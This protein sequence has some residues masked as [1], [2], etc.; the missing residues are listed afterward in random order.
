MQTKHRAVGFLFAGAFLILTGF[1]AASCKHQDTV[2]AYTVRFEQPQHGKLTA[3][4]KDGSEIKSG[5]KVLNGATVIFTADPEKGYTVEKWTGELAAEAA[6]ERNISL[7]VTKDITAGVIFKHETAPPSNNPGGNQTP[8]GGQTPGNEQQYTVKFTQP[9]HGRLTAKYKEN[10]AY[11]T[12]GQTV[13]KGTTVIFTARQDPHF[14]IKEWTGLPVGMDATASEQT[15]TVESDLTVTVVFEA[16]PIPAGEIRIIFDEKKI[17]CRDTAKAN[18][19]FT[20]GSVT[21]NTKLEFT[22]FSTTEFESWCINNQPKSHE[23]TFVYEV[24]KADAQDSI[25]NV[26]YTEKEKPVIEFEKDKITVTVFEFGG[27]TIQSGDKVS[28][29]TALL[30]NVKLQPDKTVEKWMINGT[31]KA[32]KFEPRGDNQYQYTV[33]DEDAVNGKISVTFTEKT[34][35]KGKISFDAGKIAVYQWKDNKWTEISPETSIAQENKLAFRSKLPFGTI[36]KEWKI[37]IQP[38][39]HTDSQYVSN[40]IV[41]ST[42]FSSGQMNITITDRPA[43]K[44]SIKFGEKV[45]C[46]KWTPITNEETELKDGDAIQETDYLKVKSD[47]PGS[48]TWTIN[49]KKYD[50][51]SPF[52]TDEFAVKSEY[53]NSNVLKI[54]FH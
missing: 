24:K 41:K 42:D 8:D 5:D 11:I 51:S 21:E 33:A 6:K 40:Y 28:Y 23:K 20:Y 29:K 36:V 48:G 43:V 44:G 38:P 47:K 45:T 2:K 50:G 9:E 14:H 16:E 32:N 39:S 4:I 31:E 13:K 34:I 1:F 52:N 15:V 37:G 25:I 53:F 7:V 27:K 54:E 12:D 26:T 49:G 22:A 10:G 18:K 35:A 30:F 17:S 46:K 3:K 19:V